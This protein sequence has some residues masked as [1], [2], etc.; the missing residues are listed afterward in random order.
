MPDADTCYGVVEFPFFR[1]DNQDIRDI[2]KL[3]KED[4]KMNEDPVCGM[5]IDP[6]QALY[7]SDYRG[8]TYY[9]CSSVCLERFNLHPERYAHQ[10]AA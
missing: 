8:E 4:R 1:F 6:V 10:H 7:S 5:P 9:F 3:H 2:L